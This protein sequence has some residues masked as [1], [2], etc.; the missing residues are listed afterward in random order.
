MELE[1]ELRLTWPHWGWYLQLCAKLQ[2][3]GQL[4]N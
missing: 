3:L 4:L 2:V 1:H